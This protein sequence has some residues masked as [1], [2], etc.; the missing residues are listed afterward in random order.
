MLSIEFCDLTDVRQVVK[1][2]NDTCSVSAEKARLCPTICRI[3]HA[4]AAC[5]YKAIV[6]NEK[7]M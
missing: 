3:G 4:F 7:Y 2:S 5:S 1:G 6:D